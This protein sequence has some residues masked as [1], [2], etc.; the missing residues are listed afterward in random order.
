M[1]HQLFLIFFL[2]SPNVYSINEQYSY[3][4]KIY[5]LKPG[6]NLPTSFEDFKKFESNY[7]YED[8]GL[9]VAKRYSFDGM[10]ELSVYGDP[11]RAINIAFR[12]AGTR[13]GFRA[14]EAR[15]FINAVRYNTLGNMI[16]V[17][18]YLHIR[19]YGTI[20][21]IRPRDVRIIYLEGQEILTINQYARRVEKDLRESW[22]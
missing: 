13:F 6:M 10:V 2:L 16:V 7:A 20:N 15:K 14:N 3:K 9:L 22:N 12:I 8:E 18:N 17:L 11:P 5:A 21:Y 4:T 19:Q 1:K